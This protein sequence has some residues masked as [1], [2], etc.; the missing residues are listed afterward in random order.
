VANPEAVNAVCKKTYRLTSDDVEYL[1]FDWLNE[2]L[3]TYEVERVVLNQFE[4]RI[5]GSSLEA[6]CHGE[7]LAV[8]RH[9]VAHEVKA[10]T[11]HGLQVASCGDGWFAEVIVDI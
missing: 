2:L 6:T 10:I 3:F 8:E 4:V 5:E 7:P 11:Y 1:L 9:G